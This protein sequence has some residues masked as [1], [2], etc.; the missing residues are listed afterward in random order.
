MARTDIAGLLTG[1]P[2]GGPDPMA[3]GGNAA[4]QRLAFG[5]QRAQGMQ[6]GLMGAMGKDAST[7]SEKLQMAMAQLDMSNP[8]D[9]RKIAQ[10][11]QATGDLAGAA[12]TAARIKQMQEKRLDEL[13]QEEAQTGFLQFIATNYPQYTGLVQTGV[14]KPEN[15]TSFIKDK[16]EKSNL[17][18]GG[19]DQYAD[20][21][22]N[23]YYGAMI[24]D[25]DKGIRA[26]ITPVPGSPKK[27]VGKLSRVASG[28]YAGLTSDEVLETKKQLAQAKEDI[29]VEGAEQKEINKIFAI[30]RGAASDE[31]SLA[32]TS[33]KNADDMLLILDQITTGGITATGSK[34]LTDTFGLTD[35]NIGEFDTMAKQMM[36]DKLNA[37]GS[38][39]SDGERRAA[40]ELVPQI[41]KTTRLNKRIIQ[42]FKEEMAR[43]ARNREYLMTPQ[44]NF[45]NY[46]NFTI[47]QY[48]KFLDAPDKSKPKTW[49]ELTTGTREY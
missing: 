12:Q 36:V 44:A 30:K 33:V 28:A 42:R 40:A 9:L 7:P 32:A 15:W 37:F 17:G 5:A 11:Q 14:L 1:V 10:I 24:K 35:T 8:D 39:P 22:G 45:E 6:R 20:E 3:M 26:E 18:F 23:L 25:P 48:G 41:E 21:D 16:A 34:A 19:A 38:N 13:D 27:P 47:G 49:E 46:N 43:R 4:Q 31:Y 29:S 2:S